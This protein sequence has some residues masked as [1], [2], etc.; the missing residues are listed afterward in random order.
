MLWLFRY[1]AK[2]ITFAVLFYTLSSPGVQAKECVVL[3]HGLARTA[4]SMT[5]LMNS[6]VGEGFIVEN[7]D[8]P[9]RK[10]ATDELA[11]IA[12]E[13]GLD[14]CRSHGIEQISFVTHSL[15][16]ILVRYYLRDNDIPELHRV[17]MLGPPNQG[18]EVVDKLKDFPGFQFINGPAGTQLGT[19]ATDIPKSMGPVDFELGIIAG[20][21]SINLILSALLPNPND[22][23]VSVENT[24]VEGMSDFV[25][26][27]ASHP[28]LMNNDRVISQVI[29]FLE[30]G[31]FNRDDP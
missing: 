21:K 19:L 9:S 25:A 16:G 13:E 4:G 15:G 26:L 14:R 12:I 3:L 24:K 18:S 7:I 28:F 20:T 8:Y 22:G 5:R 23:K 29:H 27:P 17:V 2:P 6:L 30:F 10:L 31:K 1:A 11:P